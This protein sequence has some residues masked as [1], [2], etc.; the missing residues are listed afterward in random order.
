MK[1]VILI[2]STGHIGSAI[3]N[4]LINRGH[5]VTAVTRNANKIV[6]KADNLSIVEADIEN[7]SSII[8]ISKGADAVISAYNPGWANPNIYKDTL[9]NY[10]AILNAVKAAG[11]NRFLIV[12]G[13]GTLFVSPGITII[14]SG[15]IPTEILPAVKGL[16][17]FFLNT[18]KNEKEIDWIFF[19]PAGTFLD[20]G[21]RT[22]IFRLGKDDLI[23][24]AD[25]NSTISIED[26]A[27]AM[28]DE[29]ENEQHHQER[30]TIGY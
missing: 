18:L 17:E 25:G 21:K 23:V 10:S 11:V 4:E 19:S 8:E 14:D 9:K 12:G 30:F 5:Q 3:L 22:G 24:D 6:L 13:A 27:V 28:V 20:N 26:Y 1:K 7:E 29:L 2:G 16:A 15:I